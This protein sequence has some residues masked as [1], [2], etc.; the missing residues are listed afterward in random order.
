M[1]S[2]KPITNVFPV[3]LVIAVLLFTGACDESFEPWQENDQYHFSIYG[4]LDASADTQWVRVMPVREDIFME[5]KPI[6][7]TVTIEHIESGEIIE[8][9]DSLFEFSHDAFAY[10]F[11]TTMDILPDQNYQLTA[12]RSD[13]KTSQVSVTLPPDFPV[14]FVRVERQSSRDPTPIRATVVI[15]EVERL[16]DVQTVY[17]SRD[18]QNMITIPH[19]K[20]SVRSS[21]GDLQII[22]NP[23][24]DFPPLSSFF[25]LPQEVSSVNFL[26][27]Q[28]IKQHVFIASAGPDYYFFPAIGEKVISLPEGPSNIIEGVGYLAGLVSK[29]IPYESCFEEE[30][31]NILITCEPVPPPW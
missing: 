4:Y 6:D 1:N 20:D 13:G 21:S 3:L 16:A 15:Q 10:N 25:P 5:P 14:P 7:A 22:M 19:L 31:E 23:Q 18:D 27:T 29:T 8:L 24:E 17:R 12:E 11:W 30:E 28:A 2:H 9:N 26:D